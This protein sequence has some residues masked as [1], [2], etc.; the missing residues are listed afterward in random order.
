[1]RLRWMLL[2]VLALGSG[3]VA[4]SGD[5]KSSGSG[6][7]DGA[8]DGDSAGDGDA[9]SGDG[10]GDGDGDADSG[11]GDGDAQVFDVQPSEPQTL[12]VDLA[13][14][15]PPTVI[16]TA[17]LN[18]QP[19]EAGWNVDRGEIGAIVAGTGGQATFTPS[20]Q[21]GGLVTVRAGLNGKVLERQVMVK[22]HAT[23]NGP[24]PDSAAEQAQIAID[25]PSL[26]AGGGI[27]GVGGEG[28]GTAIA[29]AATRDLLDTPTGDAAAKHLELLYPYDATVFP[30]GILAPLLMWRSDLNGVDAIK[31]ELRTTSGSF[32]WSGK[33]AAPA[34]LGTTNGP[35]SR[36]PIPQDAWTKATDTAGSLTPQGESDKLEVSLTVAK[37]GESYGPVTQ[38]WNIAAARLSGTIYYSSYGTNLAKNESGAVGGDG[39][40]GGAVLS[41]RVGDTGPELAA[42]TDGGA[43]ECRVCHSTSADGSRL[44]ALQGGSYDGYAYDLGTMGVSAGQDMNKSGAEYP[45]LT[46]D[47]RYA[48]SPDGVLLDL[49]NAGAVVSTTGLSE[50]AGALG[51]SSF[52]Y[53]STKVAFNPMDSDSLSDPRRKLV[54][55]SFDPAG[56]AFADAVTVVDNSAEANAQMRPGWPTFTPDGALVFHQ[57]IAAGSDGNGQAAL[58][59]RKGAKAYLAWTPADAANPTPL[60]RLN[61]LDAAGTSYLPSLSTAISM[62]CKGDGVEVG[63][64]DNDHADDENLNYEPTVNPIASGGYAWVVFTS[65]RMYG[66]VADIPPFCSDPR[67]VNLI[68]HVTPKKLWVAAIDLRG[69]PGTDISHPAFYLPAQELLAGNTR[70]AW[71]LDPCRDDGASC[72]TGDQCCNGYC[73]PD[74]EG[75]LVCANEPPDNACSGLSERCDE[76]ADCCDS[77]NECINGFCSQIVLQ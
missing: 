32:A 54:V 61:G 66:N 50:V 10:D 26:T 9:D 52:S 72:A 46:S 60:N 34:I 21:T 77:T 5:S 73:S 3:G 15:S 2:V 44:F 62:S 63:A 23:Q 47:G 65:R 30:R 31:I 69:E 57:Q 75:Q 29:D 41:I 27:G 45:G 68:D 18:G 42:G 53:D 70:G 20:M 59:T 40:F 16:F 51:P 36:H 24:N 55:M 11:D 49:E 19:I 6:D 35:F 1:M 71:V 22:L 38:T 13:D 28:L 4:C 12:T 8:G 39:K 43:A 25:V 33:F 76:K 48:L 67:G 56:M 58:R 64:I 17:T 37:G 14:A 74:A 7:E